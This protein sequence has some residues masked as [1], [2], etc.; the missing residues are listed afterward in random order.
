MT[1]TRWQQTPVLTMAALALGALGAWPGDVVAQPAAAQGVVDAAL[2]AGRGGPPFDPPGRG[3]GRGNDRGND[4]RDDSRV[5]FTWSGRVDREVLITMRGRDLD[6]RGDR[7]LNRGRGGQPRA[8]GALPRTDGDVWVRVNEGRGDVDVIQQP[9]ARN[10]Y[11][12]VVR[13][14]DARAGDDR[15]RLTA[16]W[17]PD[18]RGRWGRDDD[19]GRD[20]DGAWGR[21]RDG[22]WGRDRGGDWGRGGAFAGARWSGL[23]DDVVDLRIQGR[24]IRTEERSGAPTR[25][26][27]SSIG[28]PLPRGNTQVR[29]LRAAG[30][31]DVSVVQQPAIWNNYTA[32]VRIRDAR[33][34]AD[35]YD[36]ELAW[37]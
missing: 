28:Q 21:G 12:A 34:G 5:L 27:R 35:R 25:D 31:G 6:L 7:D 8:N 33:G 10:N 36:V 13:I 4:R 32:I 23:V 30:R 1:V 19:R 15:Y 18:D 14:R 17:A 26:V 20:R 9:T 29:I 3:N 11:T 37:Q 24:D 16:Y 2:R 22:D